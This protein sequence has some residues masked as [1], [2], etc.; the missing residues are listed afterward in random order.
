MRNEYLEYTNLNFEYMNES[1][2]FTNESVEYTNDYFEYTNE[3]IEY[4]NW[5][6]GV[7]PDL[8]QMREA[9]S[10]SKSNARNDFQNG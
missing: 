5:G 3:Y 7:V 10:F 4:T 9:Y 8:V 1:V 2:D 6:S